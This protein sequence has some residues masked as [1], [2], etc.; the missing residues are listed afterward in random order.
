MCAPCRT[1]EAP[2]SRAPQHSSL[3]CSSGAARP[4]STCRPARATCST[5]SEGAATVNVLPTTSLAKGA[6]R[7]GIYRATV[8]GELIFRT[9]GTGDAD[10]YIKKGSEPSMTS[11]D[12][13]SEGPTATEEARITVAVGDQSTTS[14][15]ATPLRPRGS[16]VVSPDAGQPST[17]IELLRAA[18]IARGA[19]KTG[20]YTATVTRHA[21]L[22]APPAPATSTSTCKKGARRLDARSYDAK[23]EGPTADETVKH[24]RRCRATRSTTRSTATRPP[25]RASSS[26]CPAPA[27]TPSSRCAPLTERAAFTA[28]S[29]PGGGLAPRAAR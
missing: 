21:H 14:S 2:C 15:T 20:I 3:S 10:L 12:K 27:T 7:R 5:F 4:T 8:A 11:Y 24:H 17:T 23:G 13:A 16:S 9:S 25:P 1:P 18:R 28:F 6:M 19:S 29:T 22:H 26:S